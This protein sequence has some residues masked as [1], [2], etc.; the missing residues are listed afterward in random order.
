MNT[1]D[2]NMTTHDLI[3]NLRELLPLGPQIAMLVNIAADRL[4]ELQTLSNVGLSR[5]EAVIKERDEARFAANQWKADAERFVEQRNKISED[6]DSLRMHLNEVIKE[7]DKAC[8]EVE[9][10]KKELEEIKRSLRESVETRNKNFEKLIEARAEVATL[11]DAVA[12]YE[13]ATVKQ[14]LTVRPEPS[15]LEIAALFMTSSMHPTGGVTSTIGERMKWAIAVADALI[16][17]AAARGAK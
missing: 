16:A 14:S 1:E 6:R 15:R 5:L 17:A 10:L 2:K 12:A 3:K 11:K 7:R 9:R 4:E 8:A 13:T